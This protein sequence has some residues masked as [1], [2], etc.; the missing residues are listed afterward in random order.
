MTYTGQ[1]DLTFD[2]V[3]WNKAYQLRLKGEQ[4]RDPEALRLA[5]AEYFDLRMIVMMDQCLALARQ[6]STPAGAGGGES[7]RGVKHPTIPPAVEGS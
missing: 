3:R 6:Y 1:L 7:D 2:M 4:D 5:A